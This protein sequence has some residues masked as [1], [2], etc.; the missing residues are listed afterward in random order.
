MAPPTSTRKKYKRL[1]DEEAKEEYNLVLRDRQQSGRS[2]TAVLTSLS[3]KEAGFYQRKR[4]IELAMVNPT[5]YDEWKASL[6]VRE[7]SRRAALYFKEDN[8]NQLEELVT[9]GVKLQSA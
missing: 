3:I 9:R 2:L 5:L 8:R 6:S 7:M 4:I 1:S